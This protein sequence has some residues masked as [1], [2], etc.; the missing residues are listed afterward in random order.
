MGRRVEQHKAGVTKARA[1]QAPAGWQHGSW[2]THGA[3]PSS[4][5]VERRCRVLSAGQRDAAQ[6]IGQAVAGCRRRLFGGVRRAGACSHPAPDHSLN[7]C[8]FNADV[9]EPWQRWL[10]G[11]GWRWTYQHEGLLQGQ[12]RSGD[13]CVW[14]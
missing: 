1:A 5:A 8:S 3:V 14:W 4:R 9:T 7:G 11:A 13:G 2:L 6:G 12:V 10:A